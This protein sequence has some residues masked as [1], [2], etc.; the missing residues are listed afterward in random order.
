MNEADSRTHLPWKR[1]WIPRGK[2]GSSDD[3]FLFDPESA[4]A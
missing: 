1:F 3:G 2:D 4:E